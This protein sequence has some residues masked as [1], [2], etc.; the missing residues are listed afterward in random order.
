MT[1][2]SRSSISAWQVSWSLAK[3]PS[4]DSS[5]L[6]QRQGDQR[7][8][9]P[10]EIPSHSSGHSGIKDYISPECYKNFVI[11]DGAFNKKKMMKNLTPIR[12]GFKVDRVARFFVQKLPNLVTLCFK[13]DV[14]SLGVILY[15]LVYGVVPYSSVAGGRMAKLKVSMVR[16][17]MNNHQ[18][19]HNLSMSKRYPWSD[20]LWIINNLI[21]KSVN[22]PQGLNVPR[23]SG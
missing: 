3:T 23:L 9:R 7:V 5:S 17:V 22:G 10:F 8:I 20:V 12:V 6:G 2:V 1:A 19:K 13:A 18:H 21:I 4:N 16:F 11:E 15:Q 14:W